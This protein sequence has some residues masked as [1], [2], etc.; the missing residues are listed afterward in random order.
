MLKDYFLF[1]FNNLKS[2]K[3]RSWLTMLGI[4]IGIAA[5]VALIGLGE[6]LRVAINSQ[7]GFLGADLMMITTGGAHGPPGTTIVEVPFTKSNVGQIE[8]VGGVRMAAGRIANQIK[9]GYN[10]KTSFS[11]ATSMPDGEDRRDI[12]EAI[13][14]EAAKGRLLDDG[15]KYAAV[16]G[17]SLADEK[18]FGKEIMPGSKIELEDKEFKVAGILEKKGN[19]MLDS[20][21]LLNEDVQRELFEEEADEYDMIGVR[22]REGADIEEVKKDIEK[23]LRKKRDVDEGEEDFTV[24]TAQNIVENL[25]NILLSVNIFVWIIAGISLVVGG[26]GIM[27]T[28]YTAVL[29]RTRE[30]GIMKSIGARNSSIFTL[31]FMESGLLG[32]AG[33]IIGI[34]LGVF[35]ATSLAAIGR[36]ALGSELI[37][38]HFSI[39]L[40]LGALLFS[41][42]VGAVFGVLPAYKASKLNPVDAIRYS[43]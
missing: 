3:L 20:S 40:I 5:V 39:F 11:I 16:I 18:T 38:T 9:M 17:S 35:F 31:F 42:S 14:Y 36:A 13:N 21:I 29:E 10:D 4:F 30:I 43:K 33:G 32:S 37:G 24:E 41:F 8:S 2:R 1:S 28:M 26:I 25:N 27:N 34:L 6:G 23:L 19:F 22:V 7:F 15:D 12:E